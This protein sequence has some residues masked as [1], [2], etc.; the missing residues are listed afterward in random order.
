MGGLCVRRD[1]TCLLVLLVANHRHPILPFGGDLFY[2]GCDM[3]FI[4]NNFYSHYYT[5]FS[6]FCSYLVL[7]HFGDVIETDTVKPDL[8]WWVKSGEKAVTSLIPQQETHTGHR[9][10]LI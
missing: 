8:Q 9:F 1:L 7:C 10:F 5:Y 4:W 2:I 3:Q 6:F